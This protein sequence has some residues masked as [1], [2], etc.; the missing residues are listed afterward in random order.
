VHRAP[1]NGTLQAA[2]S[3]WRQRGAARHVGD[4]VY[5]LTVSVPGRGVYYMSFEISSLGLRFSDR[6]PV[7]FRTVEP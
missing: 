2:T 4:G 1:R 7:I 5:E 6:S 3:G